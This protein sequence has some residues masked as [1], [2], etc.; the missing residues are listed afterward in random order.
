MGVGVTA[1]PPFA[2]FVGVGDEGVCVGG[3]IM[4]WL[5]LVAVFVAMTLVS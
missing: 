1:T 2:T 3:G 5:A 4:G